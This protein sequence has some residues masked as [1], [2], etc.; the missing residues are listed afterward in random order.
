MKQTVILTLILI[1][2]CTTA[3]TQSAQQPAAAAPAATPA[4]TSQFKNVQVLPRDLSREQ[5]IEIM[6]NFSRSLGVRCNFCHVVAQTEPKE[7]L[8][9]PNDGK[10]EK[11][12]ARV[13][14]QMTQQING[15]WMDRVKAAEPSAAQATPP[16]AAPNG[17]GEMRVGCW[18]CHRG[19]REPEMPPPPSPQG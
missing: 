7:V 12:V 15:A 8:D 6:R 16:G 1:L 17:P 4:A 11:R 14:I 19:Q 5:L 18:T 10:E 9:F 13:M 3:T 2:G